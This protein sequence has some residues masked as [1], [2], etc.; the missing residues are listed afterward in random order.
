MS[1]PAR[2]EPALGQRW[3]L[4]DHRYG[5]ER[6]LTVTASTDER[7]HTRSDG[8]RRAV[9]FRR[10]RFGHGARWT[11]CGH[12]GPGRDLP[13]YTGAAAVTVGCG[14]CPPKPTTL[15]ADDV[16]RVDGLDDL[17]V[18]CDGEPVLGA[19]TPLVEMSWIEQ[20][21][22]SKAPQADWRIRIESMLNERLYQ[23]QGSEWVLVAIGMGYA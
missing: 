2:P 18:T 23:R 14:S 12:D 10:D 11:F 4:H 3:A 7:V 21:W 20:H 15:H 1:R 19:P 17:T 6:Y 8:R 13:P 16:L 22:V 9:S 5:R